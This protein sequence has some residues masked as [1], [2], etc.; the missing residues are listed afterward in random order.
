[1][2][3]YIYYLCRTPCWITILNSKL[4]ATINSPSFM[5]ERKDTLLS[6][7]GCTGLSIA[8]KYIN[9]SSMLLLFMQCQSSAQS[10][11][12]YNWSTF[13]GGTHPTLSFLD[14]N[15]HHCMGFSFLYESCPC[16]FIE[17]QAAEGPE[18]GVLGSLNNLF[19]IWRGLPKQPS[20]SLTQT[21]HW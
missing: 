16:W 1:M 15:L 9:S 8:W 7:C 11:F 17:L 21:A 6:I 18:M 14:G 10:R 2:W 13:L 5:K 3:K 4:C 20:S 12:L 19:Y